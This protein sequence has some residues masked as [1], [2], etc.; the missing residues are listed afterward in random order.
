MIE[1]IFWLGHASF[2][3]EST[4]RIYIDPWHIPPEC[5]PADAILI[6]HEHYDHCSIS[7]IRKIATPD[8]QIIASIGAAKVL[9]NDLQELS[10]KVL[11]PWQT[12]NIGRASIKAV[13]AYT[14]DNYH[15]ATRDDLGFLIALNQHDIYYAGDTD[16]VPEIRRMGC[17]IAILPVSAKEGIMTVEHARDL[18]ETMRPSYTVPSHY[19]V[20][21]GGTRL[22]AQTLETAIQGLSRFVWLDAAV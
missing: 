18:I 5:P 14:F 1:N 19:G 2:R 16:L 12:F 4:P 13:P 6:S 3:I 15:P 10:I 8:T 20:A 17:D 22:D 7:D 9:E 21:E 11:R